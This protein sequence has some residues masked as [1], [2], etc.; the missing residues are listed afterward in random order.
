[1]RHGGKKAMMKDILGQADL[2]EGLTENEVQRIA[3][4]ATSEELRAGEYLFL[5]GDSADRLYVLA[6]G[7]IDLCFPMSLGESLKDV[8][9]E[10]V[11]PGQTLGWSALVRPYRFT[12]SARAAEAT[13]VASFN[14][15]DLL[16]FFDSEPHIGYSVLTRI[17]E[18]VGVRLLT[19]QAL[20]ARGLQ[21]S[22]V[23]DRESESNRRTDD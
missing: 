12:L 17:S 18:L 22:M 15:T 19:V 3:A 14:R 6:T 21:R 2:L 13:K 4:I 8:C 7:E 5:L 9:V 10:T 1:V 16:A 20:W 23:G 11:N